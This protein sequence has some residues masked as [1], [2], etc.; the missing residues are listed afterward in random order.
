MHSEKEF[1]ISF[2][3]CFAALF[4][5]LALSACG[6][7]KEPE[8]TEA[9]AEESAAGTYFGTVAAEEGAEKVYLGIMHATI[10]SLQNDTGICIFRDDSDPENAWSVNTVEIGEIFV[11]MEDGGKTRAC[12]RCPERLEGVDKVA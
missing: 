2:R 12:K 11:D 4:L 8:S 1:N 6:R 9:A 10:I 7:R 5:L 3:L